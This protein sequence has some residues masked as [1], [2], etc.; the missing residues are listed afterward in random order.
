MVAGESSEGILRELVCV[1][2]RGMQ[3]SLPLLA[4]LTVPS[5]RFR[6]PP[7][8]DAVDMLLGPVG[9][10]VGTPPSA[11]DSFLAADLGEPP[12]S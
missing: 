9:F 1:C 12:C 4:L 3:V 8:F 6:S 10:R 2:E 7:L 11:P 5:S